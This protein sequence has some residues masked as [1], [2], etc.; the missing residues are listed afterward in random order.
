MFFFS[1]WELE[2]IVFHKSLLQPQSF[3]NSHV[4]AFFGTCFSREVRI[5]FDLRNNSTMP[6]LKLQNQAV[7]YSS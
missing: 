6:M 4:V 1:M 5:L 7:V 2:V 3:L